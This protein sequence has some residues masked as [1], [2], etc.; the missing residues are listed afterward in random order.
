MDARSVGTS[1]RPASTWTLELQWS[2]SQRQS[3]I[4]F[5]VS[6]QSVCVA[7]NVVG[8]YP[9]LS[10]PVPA[11]ALVLGRCEVRWAI[12]PSAQLDRITMVMRDKASGRQV[13][14]AR[15]DRP[16]PGRL[17]RGTESVVVDRRRSTG[18]L[19]KAQ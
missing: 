10:L 1:I 18:R 15:I 9:P 3:L 16:V 4:V 6:V 17:I 7:E 5:A 11:A 13:E 8:D 14:V 12:T 19:P 2:P